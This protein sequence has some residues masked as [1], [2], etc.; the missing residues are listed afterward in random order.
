MTF[1][2]KYKKD[3]EKI[4]WL[5]KMDRETLGQDECYNKHY[6]PKGKYDY[7]PI[8]DCAFKTESEKI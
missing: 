4:E 5:Y 7:C 1:D 8:C 3:L 2:E 6:F